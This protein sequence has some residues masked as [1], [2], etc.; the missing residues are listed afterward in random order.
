M[1]W[2]GVR[3]KALWTFLEAFLAA[4]IVFLGVVSVAWVDAGA[5]VIPL[6]AVIALAAG[7]V[8]AVALAL[9]V[10][11]EWVLHKKS[12]AAVVAGLLILAL[13]LML[14]GVAYARPGI[15]TPIGDTLI[16][17]LPMKAPGIPLNSYVYVP[18]GIVLRQ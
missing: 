9:T 6:P 15:P 13:V 4:V 11:K 8:G 17:P 18:R 5:F 1:D 7:T 10:V 3:T 12:V 16:S 2:K 14:P